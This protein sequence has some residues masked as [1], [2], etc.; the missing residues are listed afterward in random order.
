MV[1]KLQKM[2]QTNFKIRKWLNAEGFKD[3]HLFPNTRF[4]KD[5]RFQDLPFDGIASLDKTLVLFQCKSNMRIPKKTQPLYQK[6]SK[7]F[8]IMCLWL[9]WRDRK[10]LEVF[11][12]D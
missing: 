10:G 2:H 8:G 5:V 1:N 7:E 9:N 3:I 4:I 6:V 11:G 12:Y